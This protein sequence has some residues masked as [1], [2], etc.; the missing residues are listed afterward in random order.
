ML[1]PCKPFRFCLQ[2]PLSISLLASLLLA[3]VACSGSA[4]P[5]SPAPRAM[6]EGS[7]AATEAESKSFRSDKERMDGFVPLLWDDAAGKVYLELDTFGEDLLY[8]ES[9]AAG[10]GSNDIGLDRGQL[11]STQVV[12][13]ER[14]GKKVLLTAQNTRYRAQTDDALER[15]SVEE[16]FAKSVLW[17]FDVVAEEDDAVIVDATDFVLRD[18]HNVIGRLQRSDQGSYR[19]DSSRS[20]LF[21]ER[22]KSFPKNTELEGILTFTGSPRGAW[23][24]SV[25]PSPDAV[26]VRQHHSFIELPPLEGPGAYTPRQ[27]DSR[28]GFIPR[29]F[30]DYSQPISENLVQRYAMRHRLEKKD[31]TA[32]VSE[33]VEPIVYYLDPG[34]PEPIRSALLDGARWWAEAFEAAGFRNGYRV[35]MLPG[36]AD[37]LDVRYNVIQWVHRS[38]RG[39]SY[40]SSIV[41]PRTG[42]I[43][44]GHVSLG[45]LRVRQDFLIA[46]AL[47]APYGDDGEVPPAMEEMALARLRQLSAHEVGHTIGITHNFA[48]SV[49]GR[50][51]VMDYPH[52][53]VT[54]SNGEITLN[55][56]YDVGIG[57]WDQ[58]A[59]VW[60]YSQFAP[61]TDEEE[62]L[63]RIIAETNAQGLHFISD[64][65]ARPRGGAHPLAHLWDNGESAAAEL[66]RL[67]EVRRIALD[68][69]GERN[70]RP[71]T[72][73]S[74]LESTLVPLYLLHRY[75]IEG[76]AKVVGGLD[77]TYAYRGDEQEPTALLSP[78]EQYAALDALLASLQ[79]SQ[80]VLPDSLLEILPPPAE[81]TRRGRENFPS[82]TGPVFDPLA[83]AEVAS[84]MTVSMV[85]E[86]ERASR[87]AMH[88]ARDADQPSLL[89]VLDRLVDSTWK[90][91][92]G[93]GMETAVK[94]VTDGV[95]LD[96]L[97]QL[98]MSSRAS[99][100]A[101]S[102]A[103]LAVSELRDWLRGNPGSGRE[104]RAHRMAAAR[105]IDLFL[106]N[107]DIEQPRAQPRIPDGSPIGS[108]RMEDLF[109]VIG[110]EQAPLCSHMETI[111]A[112]VARL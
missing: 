45:S 65:D 73:L 85:L 38:T 34:T 72:A 62:A 1:R 103:L 21:R 42:E 12:R 97:Q 56:A 68:R 47:L 17:G 26:T 86:P 22:T 9:L 94:R 50:A 55:Q 5:A 70:I 49:N 83:A 102:Q 67:L 13:F 78:A 41:D 84:T 36:D 95:V 58:R 64:Q 110:L 60:G 32:A 40:G 52:P 19:L 6:P 14:I 33:A 106:E 80:L 10:I 100:L 23:I 28:S 99:V 2:H 105:S 89:S 81:G 46:E 101:R 44:K 88:H 87:L 90:R 8:V 111:P 4:A 30:Q 3:S 51:S 35:E 15:R 31:P 59:V 107:P 24:R 75:Q 109:D 66:E 74:S 39:W 16:A 63:D 53:L 11:G 48:A 108:G 71:G 77:Y 104:E 82:R 54:L 93:S 92:A 7:G 61:G 57:E 20:A 76:A 18:A 79:P 37:P 98:A 43:L 25:T 112:S 96:H 69:F 29:S 91:R 27:F